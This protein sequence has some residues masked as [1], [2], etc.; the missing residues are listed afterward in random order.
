MMGKLLLDS[1]TEALLGLLS[2]TGRNDGFGMATGPP[3]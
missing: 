3:D 1:F 2:R